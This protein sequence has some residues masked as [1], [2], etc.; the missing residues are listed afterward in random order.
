[1]KIAL[2]AQGIIAKNC[3]EVFQDESFKNIKIPLIVTSNSF[4]QNEINL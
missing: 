1:M 3:I 2:L 4:Y